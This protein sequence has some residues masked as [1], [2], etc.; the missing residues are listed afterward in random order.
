MPNSEVIYFLK[1][2][3]Q[4]LG[5]FILLCILF[6]IIY[7]MRDPYYEFGS[8]NNDNL[9]YYFHNPGEIAVKKLENR[10]SN[11]NTFIF[12]SSRSFPIYAC[13]SKY[14]LFNSQ[15]T[16]PFNFLNWSENICGIYQKINYLD[17]NGYTLNHAIILFDNSITFKGNGEINPYDHYKLTGNAKYYDIYKHMTNFFLY[18]GKKLTQNLRILVGIPQESELG[19]SDDLS[20]DLY[21]TCNRI[22]DQKKF[23]SLYNIKNHPLNNEINNL[24]PRSNQLVRNKSQIANKEFNFLRSIKKILQKHHTNYIIVYAPMYNQRKINLKDEKTIE[25]IF[26]KKNIVDFSGINQITENKHFYSSD[27]HYYPI[28]GKMIVDSIAKLKKN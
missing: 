4:K 24:Y 28:V 8:H 3:F 6:I 20:N 2:F 16:I 13:Y 21:H 25:S 23:D 22:T 19:K 10:K 27:I 7:I 26:G 18:S 5:I 9:K 1:R 11:Y 14:K 12:G 17:K 15:K